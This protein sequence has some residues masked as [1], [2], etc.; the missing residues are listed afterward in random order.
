VKKRPQARPSFIS[1]A[2]LALAV[3][4]PWDPAAAVKGD[5]GGPGKL[6]DPRVKPEYLQRLLDQ[7]G[8]EIHQAS[9]G[10]VPWV[11]DRLAW[12]RLCRSL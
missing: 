8:A 5:Q 12:V 9:A 4:G 11:V 3:K 10:A 7:H 1:A 6:W 2:D